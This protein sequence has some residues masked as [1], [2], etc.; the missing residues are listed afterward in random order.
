MKRSRFSEEQVTYA[1]RQA[2]S[3]TAVADVPPGTGVLV[4]G[5]MLLLA[6]AVS[7]MAGA[8]HPSQFH[9][10]TT[11]RGVVTDIYEMRGGTIVVTLDTLP[12]VAGSARLQLE[13][14]EL[15]GAR[16]RLRR[17]GCRAMAHRRSGGRTQTR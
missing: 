11:V 4:T 7:A 17:C 6:S 13:D 12:G 2:E 5:L 15:R 3:G 14:P 10:L 9:P 1:H 8:G 16:A